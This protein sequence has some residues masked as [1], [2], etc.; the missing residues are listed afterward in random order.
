MAGDLLTKENKQ[1]SHKPAR[2]KKLVR[3]TDEQ[4]DAM[5]EWLK[6]NS[7]LYNKEKKDYLD[8]DKQDVL[9]E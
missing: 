2:K 5:S 8:V 1:Q 7:V 3:L 9:H 6:D 4:E